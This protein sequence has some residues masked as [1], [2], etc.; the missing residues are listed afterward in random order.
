MRFVVSDGF[1]NHY[2][3]IELLPRPGIWLWYTGTGLGEVHDGQIIAAFSGMLEYDS[4][5]PAAGICTASDHR[6]QLVPIDR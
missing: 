2:N 3:F 6:F 4:N 5:A 1:D